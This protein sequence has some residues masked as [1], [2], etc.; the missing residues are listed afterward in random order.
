MDAL[1]EDDS[2]IDEGHK[3][4]ESRDEDV[5]ESQTDEEEQVHSAVIF[6][7]TYIP[8]SKRATLSA[9]DPQNIIDDVEEEKRTLAEERRIAR[10]RAAVAETLRRNEE[11]KDFDENGSDSDAGMP[12]DISDYDEDVEVRILIVFIPL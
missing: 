8:K 6:K 9:K 4:E 10:N 12:E 5:D 11:T 2:E 1:F 3:L 7:P